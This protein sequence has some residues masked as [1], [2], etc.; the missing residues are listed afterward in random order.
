MSSQRLAYIKFS[1]LNKLPL[2]IYVCIYRYKN[3]RVTNFTTCWVDGVAFN[4]II[5]RQ[6]SVR[7]IYLDFVDFYLLPSSLKK[8]DK[9]S[10][11]QSECLPTLP[12][13]WLLLWNQFFKSKQFWNRFT[14][15]TCSYSFALY[16]NICYYY[17]PRVIW[18]SAVS[19]SPCP[20]TTMYFLD[21]FKYLIFLNHPIEI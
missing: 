20:K 12:L 11:K 19:N 4:I 3:I 14:V 5:H 21:V 7:H 16:L 2:T 9:K 18:I 15:S 17:I 13:I 10:R 1:L 6:R 8:G